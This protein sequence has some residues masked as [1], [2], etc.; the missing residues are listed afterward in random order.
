MIPTVFHTTAS[1]PRTPRSTFHNAMA[2]K[3]AATTAPWMG[4]TLGIPSHM[5]TPFDEDSRSKRCRRTVSR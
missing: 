2:Q 1:D 3:T 5:R 4:S